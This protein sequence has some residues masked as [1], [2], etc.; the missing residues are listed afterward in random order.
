MAATQSRPE[1]A[2]LVSVKQCRKAEEYFGWWNFRALSTT[3]IWSNGA[4]TAGR[5]G[6]KQGHRLLLL[7]NLP[8][9]HMS[10]EVERAAVV[11]RFMSG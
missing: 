8:R 2:L 5:I 10:M 6:R 1:G 7:N 9:R 11:L 3:L 4:A